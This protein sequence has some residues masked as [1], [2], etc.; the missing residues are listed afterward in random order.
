MPRQS[1]GLH[2]QV[3]KKTLG[4]SVERGG[5]D[6]R[7]ACCPSRAHTGVQTLFTTYGSVEADA[8]VGA[9]NT[10]SIDAL[11]QDTLCAEENDRPYGEE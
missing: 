8:R 10:L 9:T 11:V 1:F 7:L 3:M 5:V 2:F 4:V 6:E